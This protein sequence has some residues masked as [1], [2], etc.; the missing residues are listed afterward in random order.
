MTSIPV[1]R[2]MYMST[3]C[4]QTSDADI[5]AI[6]ATAQRFN[7]TAGIT[8]MLLC[9]ERQFLQYLEGEEQAVE[10][11]Y[12]RIAKDPRHS[13]VL[14]LFGGRYPRRVFEGW[15]MG[16]QQAGP[17]KSEAIQGAID[18]CRRSV[19]ELVPS[20]APADITAFMQ[21]FYRNSLGL[22][23]HVRI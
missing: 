18:L 20:E 10:A 17:E 4:D 14:R 15:S 6:L 13:G 12:K 11:L 9:V 19:G 8:G 7:A 21:S 16:F 5:Q 2:L 1:Y 22:R 23:D 3:V